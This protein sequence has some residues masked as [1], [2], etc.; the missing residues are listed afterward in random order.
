MV[1]NIKRMKIY[2]D[3][4]EDEYPY[5]VYASINEFVSKDEQQLFIGPLFVTY[6]QLK[7]DFLH[8]WEILVEGAQI[9]N[10]SRGFAFMMKQ[11]AMLAAA[12][13]EF[14]SDIDNHYFLD[15]HAQHNSSFQEDAEDQQPDPEIT[16]L[17]EIESKPPSRIRGPTPT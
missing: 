7:F 15:E 16:T 4:I 5:I 11:Y 3:A 17:A 12:L 1:D 8:T 6:Q 9:P 2:I 13:S 10:N 14:V